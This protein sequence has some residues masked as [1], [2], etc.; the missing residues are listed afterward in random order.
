M[1]PWTH[2][3]GPH[4]KRHLIG[5]TVLAQLIIM[6]NRH[7]DT[8]NIDDNRSNLCTPCMRCDLIM[9]AIIAILTLRF[10]CWINYSATV[11]FNFNRQPVFTSLDR[12]S[13]AGSIWRFCEL[14]WNNAGAVSWCVWEYSIPPMQGSRMGPFLLV[15]FGRQ[16]QKSLPFRRR[17]TVW[18]R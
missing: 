6:S 15:T 10:C 1:V 5:S 2:L 4:Y 9:H 13:S 12:V 16:I 14:V 11:K 18:N 3:M 17:H 7:T 8:Q